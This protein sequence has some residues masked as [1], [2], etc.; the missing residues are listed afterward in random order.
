MCV[1][2]QKMIFFNACDVQ[3]NGVHY[4]D[5]ETEHYQDFMNDSH[6]FLLLFYSNITA[7]CIFMFN[8]LSMH[9]R[10]YGTRSFRHL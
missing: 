2:F 9:S 5:F 4:H 6:F 10:S 8:C 1:I 3:T 7:L